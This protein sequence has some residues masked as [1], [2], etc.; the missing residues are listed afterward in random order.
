MDS[1]G[2]C[3]SM[4]AVSANIVQDPPSSHCV[5]MDMMSH[6]QLIPM[7]YHNFSIVQAHTPLTPLVGKSKQHLSTLGVTELMVL[8]LCPS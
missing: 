1:F 7:T 5:M 4:L 2:I 6:I 3:S 8:E